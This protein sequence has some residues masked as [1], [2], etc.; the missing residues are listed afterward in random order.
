MEPGWGASVLANT[1][2]EG[3][4]EARRQASLRSMVDE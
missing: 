3:R 1:A 2:R 4:I